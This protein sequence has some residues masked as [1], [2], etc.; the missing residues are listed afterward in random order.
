L[1]LDFYSLS[2]NFNFVLE[3]YSKIISPKANEISL[4]TSGTSASISFKRNDEF[5]RNS[6]TTSYKNIKNLFSKIKKI[7]HLPIIFDFVL[8]PNM[9]HEISLSNHKH[10][11]DPHSKNPKIDLSPLLNIF[12]LLMVKYKKHK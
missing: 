9:Y 6:I 5:V 12:L 10:I 8:Y 4:L 3:S 1:T 7:K 2:K 11:I